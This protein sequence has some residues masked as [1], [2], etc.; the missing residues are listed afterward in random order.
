MG[1]IVLREVVPMGEGA[2]IYV[3]DD[4]LTLHDMLREALG[5]SINGREIRPTRYE[6][7]AYYPNLEANNVRNAH[8]PRR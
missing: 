4:R 5:V 6:I 2:P 1:T 3:D 8:E 7:L